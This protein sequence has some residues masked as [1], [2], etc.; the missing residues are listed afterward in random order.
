MTIAFNVYEFLINKSASFWLKT[1]PSNNKKS[2]IGPEHITINT[3][4]FKLTTI[5]MKHVNL[6]YYLPHVCHDYDHNYR[7]THTHNGGTILYSLVVVI[8]TTSNYLS[9]QSLFLL[10][11]FLCHSHQIFV[12]VL[13]CI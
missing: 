6:Y 7:H 10:N 2:S 1:F 8:H 9:K 5:T 4:V 11:L 13:Q 12:Y 3:S